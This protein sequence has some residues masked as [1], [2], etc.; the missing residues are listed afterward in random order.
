MM[1]IL[2]MPSGTPQFAA[3]FIITRYSYLTHNQWA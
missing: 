2:R 3:R 1:A